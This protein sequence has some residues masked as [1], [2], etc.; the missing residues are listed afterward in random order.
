MNIILFGAT[1]SIG[2]LVLKQA[3]EAGHQVTAFARNIDK[4]EI[5]HERLVKV[6]G[7]V[8]DAAAVSAVIPGHDAVMITLGAGAKGQV[9]APGTLNVI[10]AMQQQG[11]SRLICQS[12]LGAGDSWSNLN[13]FWKYVMFNGLLRQAFADHQLQESYIKASGLDWT[14]V[15]P[16]AFTDKAIATDF[17]HGFPANTKTTLKISRTDVARFLIQQLASSEYLRKTPGL[18][19]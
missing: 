12:T 4:I 17:K 14:I 8:L 18:S 10:Q 5:K 13:V 2:K 6:Q 9:R 16:G 15:R 3:L 19:Y 11:P 1:G 7:N